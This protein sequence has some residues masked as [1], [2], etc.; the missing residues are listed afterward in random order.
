MFKDAILG[1]I[2]SENL[3]HFRRNVHKSVQDVY[4]LNKTGKNNRQNLKI[5]CEVFSY[6]SPGQNLNTILAESPQ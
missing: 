4:L 1:C 5:I 2:S 6:G 3:R